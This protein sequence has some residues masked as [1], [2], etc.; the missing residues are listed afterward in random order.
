MNDLKFGLSMKSA[1]KL[2]L[3]GKDYSLYRQFEGND[4]SLDDFKNRAY[5]INWNIFVIL[6]ISGFFLS[7]FFYIVLFTMLWYKPLCHIFHLNNR[8]KRYNIYQFGK[9]KG[10]IEN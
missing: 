6:L 10:L 7:Y 5:K 8:V 9:I 1:W 2:F 4:S 3:R